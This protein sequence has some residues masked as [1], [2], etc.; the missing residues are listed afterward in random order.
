MSRK[1]NR[2]TSSNCTTPNDCDSTSRVPKKLKNAGLALII[3]AALCLFFT[4]SLTYSTRSDIITRSKTNNT[5][6]ALEKIVFKLQELKK[7]SELFAIDVAYN[8]L[9]V[10][11]SKQSQEPVQLPTTVLDPARNL[12]WLDDSSDE[13]MKAEWMANVRVFGDRYKELVSS[14][15]HLVTQVSIEHIMEQCHFNAE[16][17]SF[18][19]SE[20]LPNLAQYNKYN[21]WTIFIEWIVY[22]NTMNRFY[23]E[24]APETVG[25]ETIN[26][27]T[28]DC[29]L[30]KRLYYELST[31]VT[32]DDAI[33]KTR[34]H[35]TSQY[36]KLQ[37]SR[38]NNVNL[39]LLGVGINIELRIMLNILS[40]ALLLTY[41]YYYYFW[42]MFSF[43]SADVIC[44]HQ[45]DVFP[46]VI[47]SMQPSNTNHGVT[48]KIGVLFFLLITLSPLLVMLIGLATRFSFET[49]VVIDKYIPLSGVRD[50]TSS[51]VIVDIVFYSV[52]C[53]TGRIA[54]EMTSRNSKK[55]R[56]FSRFALA[57]LFCLMFYIVVFEL[58]RW[59][60]AVKL[61]IQYLVM[62]STTILTLYIT[63][64]R[65]RSLPV[66]LIAVASLALF[67]FDFFAYKY[68]AYLI[69]SN[70]P[71]FNAY[72]FT[73]FHIAEAL[74][75]PVEFVFK[76][77]L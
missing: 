25:D 9:K 62:T 67:I 58:Y 63:S 60:N 18:L 53:F 3:I 46:F 44:K 77:A 54:S 16:Q 39:Q 33:A 20:L 70:D 68:N 66:Q 19:K 12:I 57:P 55:I 40:A 29:S 56:I 5:I 14:K 32:I 34:D 43:L 74:Y 45:L 48:S 75:R 24:L 22:D 27:D 8:Q 23:C 31:C 37:S 35:V 71:L 30:Q 72:E 11:Q 4:I 73:A 6:I 17:E 76:I 2:V 42:K 51:S 1:S 15:K 7:N 61:S 13:S 47:G 28:F 50:R 10:F 69:S 59:D 36:Q 38:S 65:L 26:K 64:A 52:I 41:A 49:F 21:N